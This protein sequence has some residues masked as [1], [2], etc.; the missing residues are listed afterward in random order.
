MKMVFAI[1]HND[2]GP[3]V[4]SVL[5][6]EGFPVTKMAS[7]GGFLM[8]GN[9]T[10]I[11]GAEDNQ[12]DK[13]IDLI[14]RYSKRRTQS[15]MGDAGIAPTYTGGSGIPV[16]VQVGGATIFVLNIERFERV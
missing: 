8:S 3:L 13:I 2:D 9:T 11:M 7:T 14:S 10:F 4:S 6:K 16:E 5:T 15:V 1:V 12:I